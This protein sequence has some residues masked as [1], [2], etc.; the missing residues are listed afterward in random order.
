MNIL[1]KSDF[2]ILE[3][4]TIEQFFPLI[5]SDSHRHEIIWQ[6]RKSYEIIWRVFHCAKTILEDWNCNF[7]EMGKSDEFFL[8]CQVMYDNWDYERMDPLIVE[9]AP[10]N[11]F[12][13]ENG[14]HRS[15]VLGCIL[16]QEKEQFR[17]LPVL[18]T[19]K[20]K[21]DTESDTSI[22]ISYSAEEFLQWSRLANKGEPIGKIPSQLRLTDRKLYEKRLTEASLVWRDLM[23]QDA[24]GAH[25]H[26]KL[27]VR[28]N[29]LQFDEIVIDA[30]TE[31]VAI[32]AA[33]IADAAIHKIQAGDIIFPFFNPTLE[34]LPPYY[35]SARAKGGS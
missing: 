33:F 1:N 34:I 9:I 17:P 25:I 22:Q 32:G 18:N 15:F 29:N 28:D 19:A 24:T 2:A 23:N 35:L 30:E 31:Q 14:H 3:H 10:P 26:A 21:F 12:R 20:L 11:I 13:L 7:A 4:I 8:Q 6:Q 16:L 5:C 27:H